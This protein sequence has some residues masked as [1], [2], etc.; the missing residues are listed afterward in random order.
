MVV[1]AGT[2]PA[3][4]ARLHAEAVKALKSREIG[5]R[6]AAEGSDAVASTP[7]EFGAYIRNEI[8]KW[9][10]VVREARLKVD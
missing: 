1:P 4:I 9:A 8:A 2:P 7:A 3:L 5:D 10:K 6:L